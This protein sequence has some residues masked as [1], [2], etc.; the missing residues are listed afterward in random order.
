M[1]EIESLELEAAEAQR[2]AVDA[3]NQ[4]SIARLQA[5]SR[6]RLAVEREVAIARAD[7]LRREHDAAVERAFAAKNAVAVAEVAHGRAMTTA[8]RKSLVAARDEELDARC[9]ARALELDVADARQRADASDQAGT[10]YRQACNGS[11]SWELG[12]TSVQ[13]ANELE[14]RISQTGRFVLPAERLFLGERGVVIECSEEPTDPGFAA[15]V[16]TLRS[17]RRRVWV[18]ASRKCT[19]DELD[20]IGAFAA[21]RLRGERVDEGSGFIRPGLREKSKWPGPDGAVSPR[22][23]ADLADLQNE[24]VDG[25]PRVYNLHDA[26]TIDP[27]D[28]DA[29]R[30]AA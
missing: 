9:R 20:R 19:A 24:G 17:G 21:L 23:R 28:L 16:S 6:G 2:R 22:D 3:R 11:S 5:V 26:A 27:G 13:S 30:E 7:A 8:S 4:A 10:D 29:R 15:I 25:A 14:R 1:N 18:L 12:S